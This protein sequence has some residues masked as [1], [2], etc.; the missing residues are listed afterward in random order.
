MSLYKDINENIWTGLDCGI[1]KIENKS[2]IKIYKNPNGK[3]GTV[4]CSLIKDDILYLGTNQ[5]LFYK[6]V[7]DT[8]DFK[9]INETKGQVWNLKKST[10]TCSAVT[11]TEL[12][13]FVT[14]KLKKYV[15]FQEHGIL[16]PTKTKKT[17][18]FKA[19]ILDC[20]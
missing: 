3:L 8:S 4:Y 16:S 2:A 1:S 14:T 5:G 13:L 10:M 11:I 15:I 20:I 7:D 19:I 18:L 6:F 12:L 9:I 17:Y